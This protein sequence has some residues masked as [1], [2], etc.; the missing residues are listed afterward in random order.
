[1]TGTAGSGGEA[2]KPQAAP[3][4]IAAPDIAPYRAGNAGIP[5]VATLDSGKPGPHVLV[6]AAVHGN[7]LCGVHALLFLF[8]R[9]IAPKRGRLSLAFCNTDAYQRFDP[10]NPSGSRYVDEDFNRVWDPAVLNGT[11]TSV[12]LRRARELRPFIDTV[13]LLLDVHSMQTTARPL[14]LAGPLDKGLELARRVAIPE[15]VVVDEGHAA[16][17]RMR[18]YGGFGDPASPKNALLV[19][20][21]QHWVKQTVEVAID[22]VLRFLIAAG[23]ADAAEIAR[24]RALPRPPAQRVIR[25]TQA[26]TVKTPDFAFVRDFVGLEVIEAAGTVIAR[27]GSEEVRTPYDGCVLIMPSRRLA[28]GLTAVR[29]G[30][31]TA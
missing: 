24:H 6:T 12:E 10:A 25:V 4:E 8:E 31:F 30:R 20:C 18:D 22:T 5:F 26:V 2:A 19:E 21:G 13:D 23:T 1:M 3:V 15:L 28:P 17:R 27:D 11:R 7:E 9:A 16:G 29:L 14:M